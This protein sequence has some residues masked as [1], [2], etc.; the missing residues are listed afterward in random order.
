MS[1]VTQAEVIE[2]I[3]HKKDI[4]E[5][6]VKLDRERSYNPASFV[7]LTLDLVTAS[8]IWPESR[9][10]SIAS[11]EK[12]I[13]KFI[14]KEV[15]KYTKRIFNELKVGDLC[16][17]KYPFGDMFKKDLSNENHLFIAGGV[18]ITPFLGL[19]D[20]YKLI[21]KIDRINLLYSVKTF[22]DLLHYDKLKNTLENNL[23][24]FITQDEKTD[25]NNHR[26][27]LQDIENKANYKSHIYICG[28]KDFNASYKKILE[29][30]G[31]KNIYM[32]EWE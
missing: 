20:Y 22:N 16:T 31:Y 21:G 12:G 32:D 1:Y 6:I 13:M 27:T 5:Y 10:F 25:F 3:K 30:T 29:N 28:S 8:D 26:I 11:F 24:I 9:T 14:I 15:G 7:Q 4:N 18:G 2:I 19:I 17:I 23:Q